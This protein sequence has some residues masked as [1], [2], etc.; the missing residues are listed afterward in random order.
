MQRSVSKHHF[1]DIAVYT[2]S[3][4]FSIL[5][6]WTSQLRPC[7]MTLTLEP[8]LDHHF[9]CKFCVLHSTVL[10]L[11]S[12]RVW[13]SRTLPLKT[14]IV[15]GREAKRLT[16]TQCGYLIWVLISVPIELSWDDVVALGSGNMFQNLKVSS[17]TSYIFNSRWSVYILHRG[18]QQDANCKFVGIQITIAYSISSAGPD[19]FISVFDDALTEALVNI[20]CNL[21]CSLCK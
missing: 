14:R 15:L 10:L 7:A 13:R 18:G 8:E 6:H 4:H 12:N 9:I 5:T 20:D 11:Q 21:R 19:E 2:V 3:W 16:I 1:L 17:P